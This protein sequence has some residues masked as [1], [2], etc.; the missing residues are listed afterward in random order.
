M[1]KKLSPQR[2][3]ELRGRHP[4][5]SRLSGE[6]IWVFLEDLEL[7]PEQCDA[8]MAAFFRQMDQVLA[9]MD[10][11]D[12][13]PHAHAA[14]TCDSYPQEHVCSACRQHCGQAFSSEQSE[15][16]QSLP[17]FGIGCP[18]SLQQV[19]TADTLRS[20]AESPC[21]RKHEQ[22]LC[23]CFSHNPQ[24]LLKLFLEC[25]AVTP[26]DDGPQP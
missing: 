8:F 4:L 7:T 12:E 10:I 5:Y 11:M 15:W 6:A 9:V 24:E 19:D 18:L 13:N 23:T 2:H 3:K 1:P 26:A 16:M 22:V 17:P 25:W 20:S 21:Q 14:I